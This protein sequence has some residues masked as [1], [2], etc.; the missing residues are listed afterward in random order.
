MV[1]G[2]GTGSLTIQDGGTVSSDGGSVGMAVGSEWYGDGDRSGLSLNNGNNGLRLGS[3]G[4]GTLTI[5]N[6]GVVLTAP[7][8]CHRRTN[9]RRFV[10]PMASRWQLLGC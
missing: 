1:G 4:T 9:Q 2:Q 7:V 8:V 3:F 5:A 10:G 6:C